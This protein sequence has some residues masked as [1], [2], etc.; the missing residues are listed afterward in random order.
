MVF[1]RFSCGLGYPFK[2][3]K[4]ANFPAPDHQPHLSAPAFLGMLLAGGGCATWSNNGWL[5]QA[6]FN[7]QGNNVLLVK[8]EGPVCYTICHQ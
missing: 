1:L 5:S 7:G 2:R 4:G 6:T 3:L 8:I